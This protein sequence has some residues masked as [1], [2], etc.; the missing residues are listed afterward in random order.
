MI[1]DVKEITNQNGVDII[2]DPIGGEYFSKSLKVIKWGGKVLIIGFASGDI[3][4]LPTN[5]ALIKGISL[6]GVR[7]GEYFRKFP[8]KKEPA[9]NNLFKIAN[10]GKITP[11]IY[12]SHSLS[13]VIEALKKIEQRKVIGRIILKP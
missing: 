8:D 3:P 5:Y 12:E 1:N 4:S 2:Y 10:T 6:L 7:A 9:L 11:F 13:K